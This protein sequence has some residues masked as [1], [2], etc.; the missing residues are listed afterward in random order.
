MWVDDCLMI[1]GYDAIDKVI[2]EFK[3]EGF[4]LKVEDDL[5]DF[6]IL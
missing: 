3:R 1:G 5:H 2:E 6:Y 4:A